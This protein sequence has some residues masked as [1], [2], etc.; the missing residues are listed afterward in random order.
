MDPD[1]EQTS[2]VSAAL[3]AALSLIEPPGSGSGSRM[4]ELVRVHAALLVRRR[5]REEAERVRRRRQY[6]RRRSAFV[7]SSMSAVLSLITSTHRP[8]WVRNRSPGRT[9]WTSA[10]SF[11]DDAWKATFRVSRATFAYLVEQ[12]GPNIKRRRTNYREPIEPRRR[13]AIALVWFSGSGEYRTIAHMF[14]VGVATVCVIVRQVTCVIVDRLFARFVSLPS[15]A[16]L[17]ET[18]RAFRAR[19]YPQCGG[20]IGGTHVPIAPPRE[21]PDHYVNRSGWHSVILQA[22]VD[23]DVR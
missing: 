1:S 9:F 17:D 12:V 2:S 15:G 8:V 13:L 4:V 20:A 11:D 19:R 23:H 14:G 10:D 5:V 22:V 3:C 18:I 16:R 21:H 7:L 6:L